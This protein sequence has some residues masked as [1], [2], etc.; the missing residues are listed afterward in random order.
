MRGGDG[1]ASARQVSS[2]ER[3]D[4]STRITGWSYSTDGS[5][6]K[7][8][9]VYLSIMAE[10]AIRSRQLIKRTGE[11]LCE[12]QT[13]LTSAAT[14]LQQTHATCLTSV[15]ILR[16]QQRLLL[17]ASQLLKIPPRYEGYVRGNES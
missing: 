16:E 3:N 5:D 14:I 12:S 13:A 6:V 8:Q 17:S 2:T 9:R 1:G 7:V 11:L 15:A 4:P 10:H